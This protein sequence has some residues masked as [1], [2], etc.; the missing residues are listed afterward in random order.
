[1]K[2]TSIRSGKNL[3]NS[4]ILLIRKLENVIYAK[5]KNFFFSFEIT[6]KTT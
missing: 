5:K 4:L 2:I 3:L 1:M 6:T